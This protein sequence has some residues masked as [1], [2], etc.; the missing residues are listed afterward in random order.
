MDETPRRRGRPPKTASPAQTVLSAVES[1]DDSILV[2]A[3]PNAEP[4]PERSDPKWESFL[5]NQLTENEKDSKNG[6]PKAVGLR[7][8][9][10]KYI[11][12]IGVSKPSQVFPPNRDNNLTA[13]VVHSLVIRDYDGNDLEFGGTGEANVS[14]A[15][16][17]YSNYLMAVASTRAKTRAYKDALGIE[18]VAAEEVSE[19]VDILDNDEEQV[20]QGQEAGIKSLC[21]K[22][23]IN[24]TKFVN[25]GELKYTGFDDPKFTRARAKGMMVLLNKFQTNEREIPEEIL[26]ND[27]N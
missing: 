20:S 12:L 24:L 14:N 15:D 23:K 25:M 7:R 17:P 5:L 16:H 11:G 6:Y 1:I 4:I 13:V 21:K 22:L 10:N 26:L 9:I 18:T 19:I 3:D 8:L 27:S 2:P